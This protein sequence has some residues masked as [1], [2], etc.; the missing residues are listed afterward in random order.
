MTQNS[1]TFKLH[2]PKVLLIAGQQQNVGKTTLASRVIS[3]FTWTNKITAIKVTPHFH[4]STGD[5]L[6]IEK[7]TGYQI[8]RETTPDSNKDTSIMLQAGAEDA[9][10]LE[11]EPAYLEKGFIQVMKYVPDNNLVVCE[12]AALYEVIE[13]AVLLA[14]R[15]LYCKVE[16]IKES[17]LFIAADRIITFTGNGFDFAIDEL[18]IE[19][20]TWKLTKSNL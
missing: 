2:Y 13:P 18:K 6:S 19:S 1:N 4:K 8:L 14:L 15:Q 9:F 3:H 20:G 11:V 5:A 17:N 10:L 16:S 7:A 12:S